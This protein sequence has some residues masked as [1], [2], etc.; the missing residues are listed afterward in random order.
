MYNSVKG[1][2]HYV[3]QG[4]MCHLRS[5]VTIRVRAGT[6]YIDRAMLCIDTNLYHI[7]DYLFFKV[8]KI[9]AKAL[10]NPRVTLKKKKGRERNAQ[11]YYCRLCN[12]FLT[13]R[14]HLG[15]YMH[16]H[17]Y[18]YVCIGCKRIYEHVCLYNMHIHADIWGKKERKRKVKV[19]LRIIRNAQGQVVGLG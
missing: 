12:C 10:D 1:M 6:Y 7:P 17:R 8:G 3:E 9:L 15:L 18:T 13:S 4:I 16:K 5:T 14:T 19:N 11:E 2:G